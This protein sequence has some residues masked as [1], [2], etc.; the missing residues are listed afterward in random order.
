MRYHDRFH[1]A[2]NGLSRRD[3]RAIGW[4]RRRQL[5][6]N[7]VV[8]PWNSIKLSHKTSEQSRD[9]N[10]KYIYVDKLKGFLWWHS[11]FYKSLDKTHDT[12]PLSAIYSTR[13]QERNAHRLWRL[14]L[15]GR[16]RTLHCHFLQL[17]LHRQQHGA[18]SFEIFA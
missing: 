17:Q 12:C 14:L 13:R 11:G 9:F 16:C 1:L 2:S 6:W 8:T 15:S 5:K 7:I 4:T 10:T 18:G 3:Y